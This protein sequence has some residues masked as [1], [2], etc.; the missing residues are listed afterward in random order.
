MV[1]VGSLNENLR[2]SKNGEE[3]LDGGILPNGCK[4]NMDS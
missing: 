3:V 1:Q 4:I 2:V